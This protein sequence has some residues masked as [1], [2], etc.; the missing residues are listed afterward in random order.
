MDRLAEMEAFVQVVDCGG[1]T[2]AAR[3]L[4]LSK[5]AV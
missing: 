2:D 3:R 5:S 4:G 1:F